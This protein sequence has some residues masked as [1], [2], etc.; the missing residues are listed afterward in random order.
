[1]EHPIA[2]G[3]ASTGED[4]LLLRA[5]RGDTAAFA[6]LIEPRLDRLLRHARAILGDEA[7]ARDATQDACISAWKNLPRLRDSSRFD[8]WL[9]RVLL[10][11]C[12]DVLRSRRRSP[13]IP[14]EDVELPDVRQ[15]PEAVTG[16]VMAAFDRLSLAERD[17]L[18][19][20]HLHGRPVIEIARVLGIPEGTAKS[21]LF[22][23][24][25]SLARA[26]ERQP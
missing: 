9:N 24:R 2:A 14:L 11:R 8:P 6:D 26:L 10:N 15:S 3:R 25:R 18:I 5:A 1:M 12:R 23:A 4:A 21:R 17:I 13:A 19:H 22:A 16:E 7:D 20:H